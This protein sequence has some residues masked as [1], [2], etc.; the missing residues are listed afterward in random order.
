M[1]S[2]WAD[3]ITIISNMQF[4]SRNL[5]KTL[6]PYREICLV[7][8]DNINSK[9]QLLD[10]PN[11]DTWVFCHL[12]HFRSLFQDTS[13]SVAWPPETRVEWDLCNHYNC[14]NTNVNQCIFFFL[15]M[16]ISRIF[17]IFS[18][19]PQ[20]PNRY[21]GTQ[22]WSPLEILEPPSGG[23]LTPG[24]NPKIQ[25]EHLTVTRSFHITLCAEAS[26]FL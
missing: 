3:V 21:S 25:S 1:Y 11:S 7:K 12:C 16:N 9:I 10:A 15:K 23:L 20:H 5:F 26:L 14:H 4:L 17:N 8:P 18:S 6:S 13:R 22:I 24:G 19:I 2:S